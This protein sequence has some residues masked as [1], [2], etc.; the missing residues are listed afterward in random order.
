MLMPGL[1][2]EKQLLNRIKSNDR[3]VL[4]E[5]FV[6]YKGMVVNYV[7]TNGGS[8]ADAEDVLQEAIVVLWQNVCSG[9]F[10][11]TAKL[12]T[13]LLGVAKNK[14]RSELRKR[15]ILAGEEPSQGTPDPDAGAL[16][17]LIDRESVGLV[18]RALETL[19]P[20]CRQLL[21][22][23]YFEERST[24]DIARIL[25]LANA[26]VVKAKKYQCKKSLETALRKLVAQG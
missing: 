15:R 5:L 16:E 3:T 12:G 24:R 23:F 22:L 19:G 7:T 25:N 1:N 26:D 6:R 10:E 13:Y 4:G 17:A 2:P 9:K 18:E 20:V 14:W 21:L 8:H 11:L